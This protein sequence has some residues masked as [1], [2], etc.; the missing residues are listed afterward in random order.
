MFLFEWQDKR[1]LH[2]GDFRYCNKMKECEHL[3]LPLSS[4]Y[5]G[6]HFMILFSYI[7]IIILNNHLIF[8]K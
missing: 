1:V 8:Y 2:V 4:V 6:I 3:K 7:N 5:L